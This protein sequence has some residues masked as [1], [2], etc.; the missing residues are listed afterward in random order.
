M[1]L[2]TFVG[3]RRISTACKFQFWTCF[4]IENSLMYSEN[5]LV[6]R[7]S[8]SCGRGCQLN[9][10]PTCDHHPAWPAGDVHHHLDGDVDDDDRVDD[11]EN[12]EFFIFNFFHVIF[13][14]VFQRK[15]F[16]LRRDLCFEEGKIFQRYVG[17]GILTFWENSRFGR[18]LPRKKLIAQLCENFHIFSWRRK[19]LFQFILEW[20]S[21]ND[22]QSEEEKV[23]QSF[24]S[25]WNDEVLSH[26][27]GPSFPYLE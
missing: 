18:L 20:F 19:W 7:V 3:T 10:H 12:W 24:D 26:K 23:G 25:S 5:K 11:N 2:A 27:S 9:N 17:D 16:W 1:E 14:K 22:F 4:T 15:F 8:E 13:R 21:W 6:G